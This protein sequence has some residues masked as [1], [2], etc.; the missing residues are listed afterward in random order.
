MSEWQPIE[1]APK[2]GSEILVGYMHIDTLCVHNAFW[3]DYDEECPNETGW[4]TYSYSEVSRTKLDGIYSPTHWMKL[5][6]LP[7]D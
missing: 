3:L 7:K 5:I 4:W 1:T 6:P 2:D